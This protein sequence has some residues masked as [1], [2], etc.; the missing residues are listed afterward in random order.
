M[1]STTLLLLQSFL[2]F[3]QLANVAFDMLPKP[4]P[5][6]LSAFIG[7]FQY[8]TQHVGNKTDPAQAKN[9]PATNAVGL[10]LAIALLCPLAAQAQE[11]EPEPQNA[12]FA[13]A[14][15]TTDDASVQSFQFSA[16]FRKQLTGALHIMTFWD[17]S[18]VQL[19]PFDLSHAQYSGSQALTLKLYQP[20]QW[21]S[22]WALGDAGLV[23]TEDVATGA[24]FGGGGYADI[25]FG[26]RIHV[27]VMPKVTKNTLTGTAF[28]TRVYLGSA[29]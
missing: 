23:G 22:F 11:A 2:I 21:L 6:I 12:M 1:S 29:F 15:A 28:E 17:V 18:G 10:L 7:A 27:L 24:K 3:L 19:K 9:S 25:D 5:I 16:A 4:W 13:G 14:V 20:R 26:R 8:F